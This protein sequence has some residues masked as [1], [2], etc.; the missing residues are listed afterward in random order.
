MKI[1]LKFFNISNEISNYLRVVGELKIE[2]IEKENKTKKTARV[3]LV[4]LVA[5]A[6]G[7][8]FL[9]KGIKA[10]NEVQSNSGKVESKN[11]LVDIDLSQETF[12]LG[13]TAKGG[14]TVHGSHCFILWLV[15]VVTTVTI[16]CICVH[17]K[18][19]KPRQEKIREK[20]K[21]KEEENEMKME[22]RFR[23]VVDG[24]DEEHEKTVAKL[25]NEVAAAKRAA[26]AARQAADLSNV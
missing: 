14:S 5:L 2:K 25:L 10:G 20:R 7:I 26:E 17:A 1:P 8:F 11:A 19:F 12:S 18:W 9:V 13:D 15:A 22:Q 24:K 23:E 16:F 6:V 3:T 4:I 21:K